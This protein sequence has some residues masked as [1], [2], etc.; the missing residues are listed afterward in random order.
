M[1]YRKFSEKVNNYNYFKTNVLKNQ[2]GNFRTFQNQILAWGREGKVHQLK[3]GLYTLNDDERRVPLSPFLISNILCTPSY[4]SLESALAYYG[5]I[6]ERVSQVT[7]VS[8]KKTKRFQNYYG[9]FN[10]QTLKKEVFFGYDFVQDRQDLSV[11]V[12]LPEKA[13]LDKVYLDRLVRMEPGYFLEHLRLQHY[14]TLSQRRLKSFAKRF[15]STKVL[16]MAKVLCDL[17]RQENQ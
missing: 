13:I 7:A 1:N 6:P 12:A 5:L 9:A 8:P 15:E 3:R 16:R 4:V 14:E 10:Y 2:F 17:I 11:L